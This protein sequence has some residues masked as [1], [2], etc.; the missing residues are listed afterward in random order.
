MWWV[1]WRCLLFLVPD[2]F[3]YHGSVAEIHIPPLWS[4]DEVEECFVV[5]DSVGQK[6]AYVYFENEPGR[7]AAKLLTKDEARRIH[8]H[9]KTARRLGYITL[10]QVKNP[11]A[12][13]LICRK[14]ISTV[15]STIS[16]S[17]CSTRHTDT[18]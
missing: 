12:G 11:K 14:E 18:S 4:V 5:T 15:R 13:P 8:Q 3:P 2:V 17:L 10:D 6:L 7:S 16:S 9:R 1:L